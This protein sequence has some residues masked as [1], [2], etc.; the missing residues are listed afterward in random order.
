MWDVEASMTN[1]CARVCLMDDVE[2]CELKGNEDAVDRPWLSSLP[3]HVR[4]SHNRPV[5]LCPFM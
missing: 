1:L 5:L 2:L 4:T 3:L